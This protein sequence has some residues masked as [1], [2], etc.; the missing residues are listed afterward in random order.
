MTAWGDRILFNDFNTLNYHRLQSYRMHRLTVSV[1]LLL[2][3]IS[4][5][6]QVSIVGRIS[7]NVDGNPIPYVNIGIERSPVGTLSNMDGSFQLSI[8]EKYLQDTVLFSALGYERQAIAIQSL[9]KNT[10]LKIVLQEKITTLDQITVRAKKSKGKSFMLGNRFTKGGFLYADSLS[11]GA[12]MALLIDNKYPSYHADLHYPFYLEKLNIFID[13]NSISTFK[14]RVRF[15]DRDTLSGL[16]TIDLFA[17][18]IIITSSIKKGWFDI[19]LTHFGLQIDKPFFLAIEWIMEDQDRLSLLNQYAVYKREN[20]DK[21]YSD[22]T[23]VAGKKVGYW[24]YVDFTPG[25][26]LG[27]SPLPFSL[28]HY[29][30]YYRTNSFGEWKRAP[31]ILT[32]RLS[33]SSLEK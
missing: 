20:P 26:H 33:V 16:P 10:T 29:T 27:V 19:D 14:M 31:V 22:S 28:Q 3:T 24:N 8:P 5:F 4:C 30:C 11:A 25:T 12:A 9:M 17:K 23:I 1:L 32:A 6:S 7:N 2:S 18:D 13:K 21:V 15:L